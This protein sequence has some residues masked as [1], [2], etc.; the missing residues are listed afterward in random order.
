[1]PA[2]NLDLW[3]ESKLEQFSENRG[4][5]HYEITRESVARARELGL[6]SSEILTFLATTG[7]PPVAAN[8]ALTVRG[9]SGEVQPVA[10]EQVQIVAAEPEVLAQMASIS[11][12]RALLWLRRRRG[13]GAG[14]SGGCAQTPSR[15]PKAR[16]RLGRRARNAFGR[17]Q[18][19]TRRT[20]AAAQNGPPRAASR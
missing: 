17:A 14:E 13:R 10:L 7:A 19:A 1:M 8:V 9:W 15:T 18:S 16:H 12:V 2:A 20:G 6:K 5:G 11:Q 3:L 4:D